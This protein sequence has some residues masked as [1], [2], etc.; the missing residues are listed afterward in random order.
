M[1]A[2]TAVSIRNRKGG[3]GMKKRKIIGAKAELLETVS[4]KGGVT[5]EKGSIVTIF[6]SFRGYGLEDEQGRQITR[7]DKHSVKFID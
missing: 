2:A 1:D 7:V 6:Q 4:N 5:F 3:G